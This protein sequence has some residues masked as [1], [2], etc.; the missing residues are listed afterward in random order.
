[1]ANVR[2]LGAAVL[3]AAVLTACDSS[4]PDLKANPDPKPQPTQSTASTQPTTTAT[5]RLDRYNPTH[6]PSVCVKL[7]PD[8]TVRITHVKPA[9]DY[10][11]SKMDAAVYGKCG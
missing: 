11:P 9:P 5:S 4:N 10:D 1:M 7:N 8:D 2:Y 3:L 6:D